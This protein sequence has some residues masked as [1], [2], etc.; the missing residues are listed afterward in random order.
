MA[1]TKATKKQ[2]KNAT[3]TSRDDGSAD[4][5]RAEKRLSKALAGVDDAREKV[6][7]RERDLAKLMA[8]YGRTVPDSATADD[9]IPLEA[10][11]QTASANRAAQPVAERAGIEQADVPI[12]LPAATDSDLH[13]A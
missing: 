7:R 11:S 4:I 6:L 3:S 10:A 9:V 2:S 8:R 1:K 13:D 5:R 12:E